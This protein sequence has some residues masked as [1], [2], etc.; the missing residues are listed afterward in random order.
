[1][2]KSVII[3]SLAALL[4]AACSPK[5]YVIEGVVPDESYDNQK[6]YMYDYN[7]RSY[8]DSALIVNGKFTF[9]G[10]SDEPALR[11]IRIDR[12][13]AIVILENGKIYVDMSNPEGAKG[14]PLNNELTK[15]ALEIELAT[16]RENFDIVNSKFFNA[17]KNN[18]LGAYILVNWSSAFSSDPDRFDL[19]YAQAGD[20]VRNFEPLKIIIEAN[21]RKRQTAEGN[22]FTDF[23]IENGN[24]DGSAASFSDYV[25]NG[26]FVLVDFWASWCGPCIAEIPL[27]VD[28]YNEHRGDNF[29]ILGVAVWEEREETMKYIENHGSQWPQIIAAGSIPTDLYGISGIPHIIL[30]GP[31]GTIIA[32]GLRGDRLKAKVEESLCDCN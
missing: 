9:T 28:V 7:T 29:E 19:L 16:D 13:Q 18:A 26:K 6:V 23:T 22:H 24:L 8:A 27:L 4:F 14:T 15:Y 11:M 1:M 17:N 32:R 25:G 10:S 12:L 3:S 20:V 5:S 31:D 2:N 21:A 30:F